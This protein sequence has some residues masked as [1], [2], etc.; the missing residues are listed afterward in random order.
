M[1][2]LRNGFTLNA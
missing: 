2:A 1:P